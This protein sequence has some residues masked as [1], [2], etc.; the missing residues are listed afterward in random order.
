M[1]R[2]DLETNA[3]MV[4]GSRYFQYRETRQR[5]KTVTGP[6]MAVSQQW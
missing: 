3:L 5:H 4:L 1:N 2:G 6:I